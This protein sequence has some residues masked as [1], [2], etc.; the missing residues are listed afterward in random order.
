MESGQLPPV[1]LNVHVSLNTYS[2]TH[3]QYK[4]H[5]HVSI[6]Y[7]HMYTACLYSCRFPGQLD[8]QCLL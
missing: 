4:T 7:I 2:V 8:N 5:A 1:V 3:V 6:M